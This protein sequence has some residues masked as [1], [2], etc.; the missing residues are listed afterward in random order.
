M[1]KN[2][3][4]SFDDVLRRELGLETD[5]DLPVDVAQYL[6]E[7]DISDTERAAVQAMYEYVRDNGECAPQDLKADV[8]PTHTAGK[9]NTEHWFSTLSDYLDACPGIERASQRRYEFDG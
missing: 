5:G 8:Q 7:L 3:G 9:N 4:E 2:P 1:K 6:A